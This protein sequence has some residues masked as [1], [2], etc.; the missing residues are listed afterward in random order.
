MRGFITSSM[1]FSSAFLCKS[2]L[3]IN[4]NLCDRGNGR[5]GNTIGEV[6]LSYYYISKSERSSSICN[7]LATGATATA[8][9]CAATSTGW[10]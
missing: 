7:V 8:A 4:N 3:T 9:G 6:L 2:S 10:L 5:F 1:F